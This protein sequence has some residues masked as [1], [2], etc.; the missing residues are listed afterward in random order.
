MNRIVL[1]FAISLLRLS[2]CFSQT[3]QPTPPIPDG[4]EL[5]R[6]DSNL[7]QME[8]QVVDKKNRPVKSL[9]A[10]D[11]ELYQD[12]KQQAIS[13]LYFVGERQ[14]LPDRTSNNEMITENI[15]PIPPSSSRSEPR[16]RLLTFVVDDGNCKSSLSGLNAA[17][18]ALIK[19]VSE[20]MGPNDRIAVYQTRPGSSLIRRYSSDKEGLLRVIKAYFILLRR[21]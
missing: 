20:Q 9:T 13:G 10:G 19:F 15:S 4:R 3:T 21:F 18:K 12:G 11:I 8:F 2:H 6:V 14:D 17:K 1:V 16:G 7:V 5:I